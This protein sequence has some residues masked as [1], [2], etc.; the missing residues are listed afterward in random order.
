MWYIQFPYG[1][2]KINKQIQ[3]NLPSDYEESQYYK[4][5]PFIKNGSPAVKIIF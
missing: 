3:F 4:E 2:V 5:V 1:F